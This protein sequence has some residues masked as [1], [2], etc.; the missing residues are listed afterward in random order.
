MIA[1]FFGSILVGLIVSALLFLPLLVWQYRRY[2]RFDALRMLWTTAGFVY[3]TAIVAFT[4]F[5][6]PGFTDGYCAAHGTRPLLDPLRFPRELVELVRSQGPRAVIGDGLVWEFVLNIVLFVPFG[7]IVR[8]V[9]EWPRGTV[10]AAAL[11]TSLLIE[12]TQLSGN[13]GLAPC[14]YRFADTTDLLTNTT[15]AVAGLGLAAITPRLLSTKAHLFAHRERARPVTRG[16][17]GLGMVLDC[18]FL[19]L[20]AVLGGTAGSTLFTLAQNG[21]GGAL[22]PE[23][24]LAL[25]RTIVTGAWIA[26]LGVIV[27]PAVIGT[28]ASLGQRTVYLAPVAMN[29]SRVRLLARALTVQGAMVTALFCGFPSALLVV[30]LGATT[31]LAVAVDPRGLSCLLTGCRLRDARQPASGAVADGPGT[32]AV[33]ARE[34]VGATR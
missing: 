7:L 3:A 27:V 9:M 32:G 6:L 16:R 24:Y 8:R 34:P 31:L 20:A 11:G 4:V 18:W 33:L 30:P 1:Q 12:L 17:R 21:G 23:Q 5:P 25:E 15:G 22:S 2:G 29:G 10:L 14:A 26:A 13:W 28:G 19:V